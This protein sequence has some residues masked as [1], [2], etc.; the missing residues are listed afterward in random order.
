MT[1]HRGKPISALKKITISSPSIQNKSGDRHISY[2]VHVER[3]ESLH[4]CTLA[5]RYSDFYKLH[6]ELTDKV[7]GVL[8]P[9]LPPK[10]YRGRFAQAFVSKRIRGLE[11]FL[12]HISEHHLLKHSRL[13]HEFLLPPDSDFTL[14]EDVPKAEMSLNDAIG[15]YMWRRSADSYID[16]EDDKFCKNADVYTTELLPITHAASEKAMALV[17]ARDAM[18]EAYIS[19]GKMFCKYADILTTPEA[20]SLK[21]LGGVLVFVTQTVNSAMKKEEDYIS[22]DLMS[23]Q[24]DLE[25]SQKNLFGTY[26]ILHQREDVSTKYRDAWSDLVSKQKRLHLLADTDDVDVRPLRGYIEVRKRDVQKLQGKLKTITERTINEI[27]QT[28]EEFHVKLYDLLEQF[29]KRQIDSMQDMNNAWTELKYQ[30]DPTLPATELAAPSTPNTSVTLQSTL[31]RS[32]ADSF[33]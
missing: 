24:E 26:R 5:Y 23:F 21:H 2:E 27:T 14:S 30:L 10:Q 15:G 13:V 8:I 7:P 6:Q 22:D 19:V 33:S 4:N 31:P 1:R 3:E 18:S 29:I 25:Y 17:E 12:D 32:N 11:R 16:G 28:R 20:G 9:P